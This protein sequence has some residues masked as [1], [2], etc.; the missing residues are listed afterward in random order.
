MKCFHFLLVF[1]RKEGTH[2]DQ[3]AV[4][5]TVNKGTS[6][7]LKN[8]IFWVSSRSLQFLIVLCLPLNQSA[9]SLCWVVN[10]SFPHHIPMR[11]GSIINP[12]LQMGTCGAESWDVTLKMIQ[13]IWTRAG[14]GCPLFPWKAAPYPLCLHTA[15]A[16]IVL[17]FD[18]L[19]PISQPMKENLQYYHQLVK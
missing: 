1:K 10:Y 6:L 4:M 5:L 15:G 8:L 16:V 13:V 7:T 3:S 2:M 14:G 19:F 9:E 17:F 11:K 18:S 12:V